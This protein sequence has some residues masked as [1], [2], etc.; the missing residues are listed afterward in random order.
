[1]QHVPDWIKEV[2]LQDG[3]FIWLSRSEGGPRIRLRIERVIA[4]TPAAD[5][6]VAAV[7]AE[8]VADAAAHT[9]AGTRGVGKRKRG[10]SIGSGEGHEE[11]TASSSHSSSSSDRDSDGV[12]EG[13]RY[14]E[15]EEEEEESA[16]EDG[17][18]SSG[19]GGAAPGAPAA[20][21]TAA[22]GGGKWRR[23]A[24]GEGNRLPCRGNTPEGTESWEVGSGGSIVLCCWKLLVGAAWPVIY[25][26]YSG[27]PQHTSHV[28]TAMPARCR[29][30]RRG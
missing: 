3:D 22:G 15:E 6:V 17:G 29:C 7:D 18:Q 21:G 4:G 10:G 20:P 14:S 26:V 13:L 16:E 5:A 25:F 24:A 9:A 30:V 1:M 19:G 27:W 2:G 8:H 12:E 23:T 11:D 28:P